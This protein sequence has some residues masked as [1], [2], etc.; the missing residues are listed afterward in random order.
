MQGSRRGGTGVLTAA[1]ERRLTNLEHRVAAYS[2]TV[3]GTGR[4]VLSGKELVVDRTTH[5]ST[6]LADIEALK[7]RVAALEV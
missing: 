5:I 7:T 1:L 6:I 4:L 3:G 2:V